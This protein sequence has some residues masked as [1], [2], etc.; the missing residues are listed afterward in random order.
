[1]KQP[2]SISYAGV[3]DIQ[4]PE[5]SLFLTV[6]KTP[7][8]IEAFLNKEK[9]CKESVTCIMDNF[10]D[11]NENFQG[12]FLRAEGGARF[13]FL[14][15]YWGSWEDLDILSHEL[16]HFVDSEARYRMFEQEWEF[17]AYLHGALFKQVRRLL[18]SLIDKQNVVQRLKKKK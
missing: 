11:V 13:L 14:K 7:N 2:K 12:F 10:K 17:K 4:T 18:G 16:F 9:V 1:M 6:N 5:C 3:V 15:E 8:Q